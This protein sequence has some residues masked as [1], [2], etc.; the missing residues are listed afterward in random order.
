M[1]IALLGMG[2]I[3][4]GV[5][6]ML[7]GREDIAVK[8]ILDRRTLGDAE[9][10][11]TERIEDILEDDQ[12]DTVVELM[13]GVEPAHS[14]AE[15]ALLAGKN[16]VSANKL[17]ICS[18]FASLLDAAK[19]TGAKMRITASVGG[20]IPY[21]ANVL[22]ARR[23]DT[24]TEIGGIVNGTTNLILDTMQTEDVDF[25]EVLAQAQAAGYAEADPSA[26][27]DGWD[28]KSKLAIAAS[29]AF[30]ALLD[31]DTI[32]VA[33][34]RNMRGGDVAN[35]RRIG[36]VCRLLTRAVRTGDGLCAY[37][38]PTLV[39]ADAPE[40][41]IH[42]NDNYIAYT[43]V[44]AG[45]QAFIGQG[46]G[47]FPTAYSVVND[48]TDLLLDA[49]QAEYVTGRDV[50]AADN[51]LAAHRY[52]VRTTATLPFPAEEIGENAYLTEAISVL[53][54][55]SAMKQIAAA[56]PNAFFAGIRE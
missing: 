36:K 11:R 8:R 16:L 23:V 6:E 30:D 38:E 51:V 7:E 45:R 29:V 53:E 2:T 27:I 24:I 41:A 20:G 12:I 4:S 31:P 35:F 37:V 19:K 32:S 28:A 46:A 22:R 14:F 10:L 44:H 54:M 40:A 3:G 15:R 48:L 13:G 47:K 9:A 33:G 43:A 50:V 21:L 39:A 49:P 5:Y 55:H 26:D 25:A 52:Y 17:M 18:D 42:K 34:I 56:D 1:N